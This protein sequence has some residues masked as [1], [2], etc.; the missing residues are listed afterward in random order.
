MLFDLSR[1]IALA[2]VVFIPLSK[3]ATRDSFTI[4]WATNSCTVTTFL[5]RLRESHQLGLGRVVIGGISIS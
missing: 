3:H 2:I 4:L 5:F 1:S